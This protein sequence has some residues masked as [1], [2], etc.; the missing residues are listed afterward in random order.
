[1]VTWPVAAGAENRKLNPT[2]QMN[3]LVMSVTFF[4]ISTIVNEYFDRGYSPFSSV[5]HSNRTCYHDKIQLFIFVKKDF[6]YICIILYLF[7]R[8]DLAFLFMI[9]Q[10]T[11]EKKKMS[12]LLI[13]NLDNHV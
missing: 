2:C 10:M 5:D 4:I 11:K 3:F 8:N 9:V 6:L 1:M 12:F 13:C 7:V